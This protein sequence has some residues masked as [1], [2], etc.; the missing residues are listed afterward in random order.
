MMWLFLPSLLLTCKK[1]QAKFDK[2]TISILRNFP[3]T[4]NMVYAFWYVLGERNQETASF[5]AFRKC[6]SRGCQQCSR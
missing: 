6:S 1:G 4:K 3:A 2:F 5:Q